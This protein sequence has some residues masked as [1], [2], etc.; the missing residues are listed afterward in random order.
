LKIR[1]SP[2]DYGLVSRSVHWLLAIAIVC[3]IPIGWYLTQL[4]NESV[5][6]WRLLELHEMLG[7]CVFILFLFKL[8]WTFISPNPDA[9]PGLARWE[10]I[11]ARVV[12]SFFL[13]AFALLPVSGYIY[14]ASGNDPI[15]LYRLI[16]LPALPS[17]TKPTAEL[18]YTIHSYTAYTCAALVLVHFMAA[19]K[20]HFADG[21]TVLKRM[22]Y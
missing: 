15:E 16:T 22:L 14:V 3:L 1:N 20:H 5:R 21:N 7:L 9:V 6:Y 12:H 10:Q 18:I 13:F 19:L 17:L 2:T 4:N 11:L 8:G